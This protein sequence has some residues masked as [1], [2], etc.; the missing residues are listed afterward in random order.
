[1]ERSFSLVHKIIFC[2]AVGCDL[3]PVMH[4]PPAHLISSTQYIRR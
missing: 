4:L 1:M 2:V 3:E